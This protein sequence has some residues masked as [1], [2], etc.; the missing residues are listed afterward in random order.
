MD[1]H[2]RHELRFPEDFLFLNVVNVVSFNE[3]FF[4]VNSQCRLFGELVLDR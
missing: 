1:G 4:K 2:F 3:L